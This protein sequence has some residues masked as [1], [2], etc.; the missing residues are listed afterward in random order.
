MRA[1]RIKG[2]GGACYHCVSHVIDR[3]AILGD[4]EKEA[5]RK[6][7][8][9][10]E[11]FCG[12]R[13]LTY[14]VAGNRFQ[15]LVEGPGRNPVSDG[16][17]IRR[18]S[19][20]YAKSQVRE[21]ERELRQRRA[22]SDAQA[23]ALKE[24]Y[25]CR[26]GDVSEFIKTL[27]QRFTQWYNARNGRRGT[28]WEEQFKSILVEGHGHA[29]ATMAAYVDLTPV[30]SG[31]AADPKDYPFSG[32]G[33]AVGGS[34]Q[35]R[36]ALGRVMERL[37]PVK[38][39]PAVRRTYRAY[40]YG[41]EE[42]GS[43]TADYPPERIRTALSEGGTLPL[44]VA[45]RCHVR[46]FADGVALGSRAFVEEVFQS[47]RSYFGAKRTSGARPMKGADWGGL[48]TARALRLSPLT[49]GD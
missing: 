42:H 36:A 33:E 18:L 22:L 41:S 28:L 43:R 8:R 6:L 47:N 27:K 23:E 16:E 40:L 25:Q 44:A 4:A 9:A 11:A 5:F 24:A 49:P 34:A 32:Y 19:A 35:A 29:L 7:L 37:S 39:W 3:R 14:A 46:Y 12:V 13:V 26:M 31:L 10:C 45:L 1:A 38:P 48:H 17:F 21:I 20:L 15:V 2:S 30:R